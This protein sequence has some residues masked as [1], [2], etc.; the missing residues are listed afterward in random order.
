MF[1]L[2]VFMTI[3]SRCPSSWLPVCLSVCRCSRMRNTLPLCGLQ[4]LLALL[5]LQTVGWGEST[6]N[7]RQAASPHSAV[8]LKAS[9]HSTPLN[10]CCCYFHL[11]NA[12][13]QPD[14]LLPGGCSH[15][16]SISRVNCKVLFLLLILS[17]MNSCFVLLFWTAALN[18]NSYIMRLSHYD[19]VCQLRQVG[20]L[21]I[22]VIFKTEGN[23]QLTL[24][25]QK[26]FEAVISSLCWLA[27]TIGTSLLPG[28]L[29]GG[30]DFHWRCCV[31]LTQRW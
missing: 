30:S 12:P 14:T 19:V 5:L 6:L 29:E 8:A 15:L 13:R 17:L 21:W 28:G 7:C 23:R 27:S 25:W 22:I 3:F 20:S 26:L 31:W 9:I 1:C 4:P 24:L 10:S 16:C 11:A 18:P 2:S